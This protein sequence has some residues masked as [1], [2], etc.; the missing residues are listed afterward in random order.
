VP[1]GALPSN[2]AV[3]Y[4]YFAADQHAFLWDVVNGL[5]DLNNLIDPGLG[6]V[7]RHATAINASVQIVGYGTIHGY[8]QAFLLMPIAAAVPVPAALLLLGGLGVLAGVAQ[9]KTRHSRRDLSVTFYEMG[10]GM[11]DRSEPPLLKSFNPRCMVGSYGGCLL[12]HA[13]F[14]ASGAPTPRPCRRR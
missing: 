14:S 10:D 7:L 13:R 12:R 6:T 11:G 1:E 5:Q 2:P 9:V 4:S 8:T 3:G